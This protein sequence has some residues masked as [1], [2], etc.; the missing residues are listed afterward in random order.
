[1]FRFTIR[2]IC[3][4]TVVV[5]LALGLWVQRQEH[6]RRIQSTRQHAEALR[7]TLADAEQ[8]ETVYFDKLANVY[9]FGPMAVEGELVNVD[10]ELID[11]PIP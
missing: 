9:G 2:D 5:A 6:G 8:N 1:M 10:W 3:W 4:I 7:R 11:A